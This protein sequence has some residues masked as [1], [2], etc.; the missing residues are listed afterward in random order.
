MRAE[1]FSYLSLCWVAWSLSRL[2]PSKMSVLPGLSLT[3]STGC[4]CHNSYNEV[5]C[6]SH[7]AL[8][9]LGFCMTYN[10]TTETA[11]YR[12]CPYI[13]CYETVSLDYVLYIQ[14]PQNTSLLNKSMCGPLN[15]DGE[16][17]GKC[18]DGYGIALYSYT[19]EC[20][21]C[22]GHGYGWALYFFL[23]LFPTTVMYFLVVIFH[24]RATSS[25]LSTLVFMSQI[26][27]YTVR[28]NITL[29]MYIENNL[30]YGTESV[31]S[32]VWYLEFRL[33]SCCYSTILCKQ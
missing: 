32:V 29:H 8:L 26:V 23:E 2:L 33:F 16:L 3:G 6:G 15:R 5:M 9:Q 30:I 14:L 7:S 31:T 19:L 20:S 21:K 11:E 13:A 10:S 1:R 12:P 25:P 17:C 27:V 24:I 22:W 4:S 28:L 18:K